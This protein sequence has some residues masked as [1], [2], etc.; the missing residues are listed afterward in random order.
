MS[1]ATVF[2]SLERVIRPFFFPCSFQFAVQQANRPVQ[3]MVCRLLSDHC[4]WPR[5]SKHGQHRRLSHIGPVCPACASMVDPFVPTWDIQEMEGSERFSRCHGVLVV[6]SFETSRHC[7]EGPY[8]RSNTL[9][10]IAP[11]KGVFL[12]LVIGS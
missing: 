7:G 9:S 1:S 12:L 2:V 6:R 5:Q 3:A 4:G 8:P 10:K 11:R